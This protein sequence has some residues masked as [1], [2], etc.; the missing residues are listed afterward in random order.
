MRNP[1]F[2]NRIDFSLPVTGDS[3]G[4][5]EDQIGVDVLESGRAADCQCASGARGVVEAAEPAQD[6]V[7]ERLHAD[8]QAGHSGLTPGLR[9]G[10]AQ[11]CGVGLGRPLHAGGIPPESLLQDVREPA[12]LT[13]EQ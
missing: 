2:N 11:R 8:A 1:G 7:I 10:S 3:F 13:P 4:Q 12:H 5:S 6:I 9:Y